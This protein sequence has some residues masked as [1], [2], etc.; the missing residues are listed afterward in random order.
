MQ[1][2]ETKYF[3]SFLK[4]TRYFWVWLAG[5]NFSLSY[6]ASKQY[7]FDEKVVVRF[8]IIDSFLQIMLIYLH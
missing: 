4:S 3:Y 6:I 8:Y 7:G 1:H 5:S 2:C